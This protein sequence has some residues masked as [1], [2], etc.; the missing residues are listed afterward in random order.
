ME[1]ANNHNQSTERASARLRRIQI[2][3][4][5]MAGVMLGAFLVT[6]F[7]LSY[8]TPDIGV[9]ILKD[10]ILL[11]ATGY[12]TVLISRY[13]HEKQQK[14]IENKA[15]YDLIKL[16]DFGVR[17]LNILSYDIR[18]LAQR[19]ASFKTADPNASLQLRYFEGALQ[20]LA[21]HANASRDDTSEM[22]KYDGELSTNNNL[23]PRST[24]NVSKNYV[25]HSS[26]KPVDEGAN[27]KIYDQKHI[28][29]VATSCPE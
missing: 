22:A 29:A 13:F 2:A 10:M 6:A 8:A 26:E 9:R 5:I 17:R 11:V 25:P 20:Q 4:P 23:I 14:T 24:G 15:K 18:D 21:R 16:A 12:F 27:S 1:N 28:S 7:Y 19:V 3:L